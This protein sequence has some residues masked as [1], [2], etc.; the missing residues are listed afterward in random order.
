MAPGLQCCVTARHATLRQRLQP[1]PQRQPLQEGG[2]AAPIPSTSNRHPAALPRSTCKPRARNRL[3]YPSRH[4][5]R[6]S[7]SIDVHNRIAHPV[8]T[9]SHCCPDLAA[10]MPLRSWSIG[11]SLP[12]R[13]TF[14]PVQFAV[15]T[16]ERKDLAQ[17]G[18]VTFVS[19]ERLRLT[20]AIN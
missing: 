9:A 10:L 12:R 8:A 17:C 4:V 2:G 14:F 19:S 13:P 11:G 20:T 18:D 16:A 1:S 7:F 6:A 3:P 5:K 15:V